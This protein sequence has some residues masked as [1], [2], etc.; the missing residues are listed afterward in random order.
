MM[1]RRPSTNKIMDLVVYS[2]RSD[3][4]IGQKP[5]PEQAETFLL[6]ANYNNPVAI[7]TPL[8]G[9]GMTSTGEW[10]NLLRLHRFVGCSIDQVLP[11]ANSRQ[12]A[13]TGL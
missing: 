4:R 12:Q 10:S 6:C 5:D 3:C 13:A 8:L 2:Q 11:N 7:N 1:I 9:I